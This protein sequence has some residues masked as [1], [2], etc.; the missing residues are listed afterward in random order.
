[1]IKHRRI[2]SLAAAAAALSAGL[3]S[4]CSGGDSASSSK[5]TSGAAPTSTAGTTVGPVSVQSVGPQTTVTAAGTGVVVTGMSGGTIT[6]LSLL[7]LGG[8][9]TG[10]PSGT[11]NG[12]GTGSGAGSGTGN[13]TGTGTGTGTGSGAG[14]GNNPAMGTGGSGNSPSGGAPTT[15]AFTRTPSGSKSQ[16]YETT[17]NNGVFSQPVNVTAN[18]FAC[19]SAAFSPDSTKIAYSCLDGSGHHQLYVMSA[20]GTGQTN[21]TNNPQ[22]EDFS[23]TW[24]PDGTKIVFERHVGTTIVQVCIM[25]A[26]GQSP[27]DLSGN[28]NVKDIAPNWCWMTNKIVYVRE[29]Q[30]IFQ[31]NS[32]GSGQTHIGST[33]ANDTNPAFSYD[34]TKIAYTHTT[35]ATATSPATSDIYVMNS[36]GSGAKDISNGNGAFLDDMPAWSPDDSKIGFQRTQKGVSLIYALNLANNQLIPVTTGA[37][38]D[39]SVAIAPPVLQPVVYIGTNGLLGASAA[40]F[41][42]G[43]QGA[44][45]TSVVAFNAVTP[46]GVTLTSQT[47]IAP[48]VPNLVFNIST[49]DN[50][51]SL[52]FL[53]GM[54][55]QPTNVFGGPTGLPA[56][57]PLPTGALISFDAYGGGVTSVLPY[58]TSRAA[59]TRPTIQNGGLVYRGQFLGVWNALGQ[60]L[61]PHGASEVRID[62]HTGH[63]L[64]VK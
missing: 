18:G 54:N 46:G 58:I 28:F 23:P 48:G 9:N 16:I 3:L 2:Y 56:L 36:D 24:S 19:D 10:P 42:L 25:G 63:I 1:M 35:A 7:T 51:T 30:G 49:A 17:V 47:G 11:G 50:L 31:M 22:A 62:A 60:N 12:T 44:N 21:I 43:Q 5:V 40:G 64:S 41:L 45:V 20:S 37:G 26:N 38:N 13:G 59:S 4:G 53:N 55:G 8:A 15:L 34:G 33:G 32:D 14:S 39:S 57:N 6:G 27:F 29:G 52:A 61:A